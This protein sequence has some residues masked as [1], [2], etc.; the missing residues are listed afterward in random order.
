ME[1]QQKPTKKIALNYGL[2]LG[3]LL[4]L[5]TLLG[6]A[7]DVSLLVSYWTM[8]YIFLAVIV[9]GIIVIKG[10]KKN[11]GGFISFKDAFKPYFIM[12]VIAILISTVVNFL[13]FNV[14]DKKFTD[15][16]K[17]KQVELVENQREWV[18]NKMANAPQE[19]VDETNDKFDE[20]IENIRNENPYSV[21]SLA[22]GFGI[23][24]SIFSFFGLILA[25]I[26]KKKNPDL[27]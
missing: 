1:D 4:V 10:E 13:L 2:I 3:F 23:F 22:K 14:I 18:M 16:V 6:Y 8:L 5:P 17:E 24:L 25:L 27:A 11:F 15:V 9:M 20:S 26:L 19:Q 21:V 7:F 12:L